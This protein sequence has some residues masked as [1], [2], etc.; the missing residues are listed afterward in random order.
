MLIQKPIE[1]ERLILRPETEADGEAIYTMNTDPEVMRF[2]G[3]PWTSPLE[4]FLEQHRK[5]L[6]EVTT[7]HY[8]N[9]SV[10]VKETQ[11]YV[12]WCGLLRQPRLGGKLELL[13]RYFRHAWGKG[14]ATETGRAVLGVGL[15]ELGLREVFA[16]CHPENLA[17]IRVLKKWTSR[18]NAAKPLRTPLWERRYDD[19]LIQSAEEMQT[20]INYIHN[21]PVRVGVVTKP[22]DYSWSSARNYAGIEP[23]KLMVTTDWR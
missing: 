16:M 18:H 4:E 5:A 2:I 7:E 8:G 19:N 9:V 22:E 21:N 12:G 11:Q 20:I 13:Y 17:S 15:R 6:A 10:I 1:T 3:D 14:Y 23:V